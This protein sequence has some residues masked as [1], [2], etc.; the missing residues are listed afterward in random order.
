MRFRNVNFTEQLMVVDLEKKVMIY[1]KKKFVFVD[2][3]KGNEVFQELN[4][5]CHRIVSYSRKVNRK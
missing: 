3:I 2:M 5:K 1:E 4:L